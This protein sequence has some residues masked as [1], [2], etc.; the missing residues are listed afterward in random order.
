MSAT[1]YVLASSHP[2]TVNVQDAQ[3]RFIV[4]QVDCPDIKA[5]EARLKIWG[6]R[7][8]F[9]TDEAEEFFGNIIFAPGEIREF[10][11]TEDL[12]RRYKAALELSTANLHDDSL[13]Y[14]ASDLGAKLRVARECGSWD[15]YVRISKHE[16]VQPLRRHG[17]PRER[18]DAGWRGVLGSGPDAG[19]SRERMGLDLGD[20]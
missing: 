20:P 3:R 6:K 8:L 2:P 15:L 17:G 5:L 7:C 1:P 19:T 13:S 12:E 10:P 14:R 18:L 4:P 11:R 16:P 9:F